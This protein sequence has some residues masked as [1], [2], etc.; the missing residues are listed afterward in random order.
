MLSEL[1]VEKIK[2]WGNEQLKG[3]GDLFDFEAE[4]D[5]SI[6]IGENLTILKDK[7]KGVLEKNAK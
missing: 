7:L 3:D 1:Q 6:T 4:I 2:E 5:R